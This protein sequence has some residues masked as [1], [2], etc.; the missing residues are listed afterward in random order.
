[1]M[2]MHYCLSPADR[3]VV[4]S[5]S[6]V[7][8]SYMA[9]RLRYVTGMGWMHGISSDHDV[10]DGLADTRYFV[11]LDRRPPDIRAGIRAARVDSLTW[12]MLNATNGTQQAV[13]AANELLMARPGR[14]AADEFQACGI[15]PGWWR[16]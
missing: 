14:C 6:A 12:R 3:A 9:L 1:M 10:Y 16:R 4:G 15:S 13:N 7:L 5:G 8:N 11:R 2:K